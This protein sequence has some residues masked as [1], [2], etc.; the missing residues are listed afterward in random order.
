MPIDLGMGFEEAKK[1]TQMTLPDGTHHFVIGKVETKYGQK[2]RVKEGSKY[3]NWWL[4]L[5]DGKTGF[6][7]TMITDAD[8]QRDMM[9]YGNLV[10]LVVGVGRGWSGTE[11]DEY[12]LV[13][14]EG[15]LNV[16]KVPRKEN[17]QPVTDE[18]GKPVMQDRIKI[19][20]PRS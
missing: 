19:I 14:A 18:D 3:L 4:K 9:G 8:G 5:D 7:I 1:A 10:N 2:A 20:K 17:G 16:T 11:F 15:F 13:G 12:S 6:Y